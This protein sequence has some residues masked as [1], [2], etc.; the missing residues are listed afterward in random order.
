MQLMLHFKRDSCRGPLSRG[1][2][3]GPRAGLIVL[4]KRE[5]SAPAMLQYMRILEI[6][7]MFTLK[8][9]CN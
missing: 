5:S 9:F 8:M 2:L 7:T 4:E 3:V 6:V 1:G